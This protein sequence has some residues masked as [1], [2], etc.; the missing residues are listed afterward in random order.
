MILIYCICHQLQILHT[1]SRA[2]IQPHTTGH[3]EFCPN[4]VKSIDIMY[5][6][7]F[8]VYCHPGCHCEI[9]GDQHPHTDEAAQQGKDFGDTG[10]NIFK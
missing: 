8:P 5:N 7:A 3:K 9:G 6:I 2:K 4:M 1:I 10:H